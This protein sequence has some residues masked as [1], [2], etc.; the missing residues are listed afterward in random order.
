MKNALMAPN[1]QNHAVPF[2]QFPNGFLDVFMTDE[3]AAPTFSEARQIRYSNCWEKLFTKALEFIQSFTYT[4]YSS[5]ICVQKEQL[6]SPGVSHLQF[7]SCNQF[8]IHHC[9]KLQGLEPRALSRGAVQ[10]RG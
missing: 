7:R 4:S 1:W 10:L 6:R 9:L 2:M 3:L 5:F 8:C